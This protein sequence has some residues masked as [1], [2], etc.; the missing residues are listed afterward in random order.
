MQCGDTI[1]RSVYRRISQ[2]LGLFPLSKNLSKAA[3]RLGGG[4]KWWSSEYL[5][6]ENQRDLGLSAATLFGGKTLEY[7]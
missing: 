3:L 7:W 1:L 2:A 5:M 6:V 4:A